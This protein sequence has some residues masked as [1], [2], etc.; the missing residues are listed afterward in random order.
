MSTSDPM[1][2]QSSFPLCAPESRCCP[3]SSSVMVASLTRVARGEALHKE[4]AKYRWQAEGA[5]TT[6][7]TLPWDAYFMQLLRDNAVVHVADGSRVPG[8][9][10]DS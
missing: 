4:Q 2:T 8:L 10:I 5:E 7:N 6:A 3:G 9:G 1:N